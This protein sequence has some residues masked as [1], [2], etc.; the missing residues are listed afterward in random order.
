MTY[1]L[2][3]LLLP[4]LT[5]ELP[6]RLADAPPEEVAQEGQ[7]PEPPRPLTLEA[8]DLPF[9]PRYGPGSALRLSVLWLQPRV[10]YD[11]REY[12]PGVYSGDVDLSR[13]AD[14]P[15]YAPGF[16]F[17][18][19]LGPVRV[20]GGFVHMAV[21]QTLDRTLCYEEETF[22]PGEEVSVLAQAGWLDVEYR[23]RLFGDAR[24]RSA[25]SALV[26]V[27]APR[28]KIT[29]ENDRASAREGFDALWP[30]PAV[31][32][33]A[34][35]WLTNRIRLHGSLMGTRLKFTNPFHEDAG[36]PQHLDFSYLR[37]D[38]GVTVDLDA[39]WS[40]TLGYTR[41]TMDVTASSKLDDKDRAIFEAGGMFLA[42]DL[43]F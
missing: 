10:S 34:H 13:R 25:V 24:S 11:T 30:V 1:I 6:K 27:N 4:G 12:N 8:P 32:V 26:G 5:D 7:E 31:G 23:L 9:N 39:R 29:V 43:R 33:E 15:R 42:V 40:L 41:F 20:D 2:S 14:L 38:A 19:D 16:A 21:R 17:S 22:E 35:Y 3:L 18:L 37:M 28:V 36:E